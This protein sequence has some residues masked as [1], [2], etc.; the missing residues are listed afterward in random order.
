MQAQLF[1][2]LLIILAAQLC[3]G[4]IGL[5]LSLAISA[6]ELIRRKIAIGF[7]NYFLW[8]KWFSFL[9]Y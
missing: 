9:R 2:F 6:V 8:K 3:F 7:F 1:A 4:L 5:I